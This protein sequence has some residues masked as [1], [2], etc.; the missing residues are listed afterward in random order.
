MTLVTG[1][2]HQVAGFQVQQQTG[3][4]CLQI[5]GSFG[6]SRCFVGS[7]HLIYFCLSWSSSVSQD[8]DGG[9][10]DDH[11]C[12]GLAHVN[13]VCKP[14]WT[15]DR[16]FKGTARSL[17]C[18]VPKTDLPFW[19]TVT[20]FNGSPGRFGGIGAYLSLWFLQCY[21]LW[22]KLPIRFLIRHERWTS[23]G[24]NVK[25]STPGVSLCILSFLQLGLDQSL[26]LDTI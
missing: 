13:V 19:F 18:S 23:P 24:M 26:V 10:S 11:N 5:H 1:G 12:F 25:A 16:H 22:S 3:N 2:G 6:S 8:Q 21:R 4:V 14:G 7:V 9:H 15:P 17:G 20:G